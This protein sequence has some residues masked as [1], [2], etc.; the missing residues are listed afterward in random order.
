MVIDLVTRDPIEN[1]FVGELNPSID[2]G[3]YADYARLISDGFT[4]FMNKKKC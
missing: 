2:L 1:G 4:K 3:D